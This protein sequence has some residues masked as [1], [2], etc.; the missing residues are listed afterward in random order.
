MIISRRTR[1]IGILMAMGAD[2]GSILKIFILE[3]LLLA[4][5]GGV[6]G[7]IVGLLAGRLISTYGPSGFGGVALTFSLRPELVAY[8]LLFALAL[9]FLAGLYPA[10]RASKLDPVEAIA[11][12]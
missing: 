1:E 3:N 12:D 6:L 10:I 9:N 5:P 8:S 11:S 7:S 4:V 2:R